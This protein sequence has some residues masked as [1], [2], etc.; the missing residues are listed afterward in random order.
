M[1]N[2]NL[3][4]YSMAISL[5]PLLTISR[6]PPAQT[7][8]THIHLLHQ[9]NEIRDIGQGLLGMVAEKRNCRVADLYVGE[10]GEF[11]VGRGD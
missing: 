7:V 1:A 11:G 3:P 8:K 10:P 9:Y 2:P 6:S 4:P 5:S